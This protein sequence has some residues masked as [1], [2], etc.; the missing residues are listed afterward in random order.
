MIKSL[1]YWVNYG[2]QVICKK[3]AWELQRRKNWMQI[4]LSRIASA[5]CAQGTMYHLAVSTKKGGGGCQAWWLPALG[6]KRQVDF[7]F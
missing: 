6:R 4:L 2:I 3:K 7:F 1:I 5:H